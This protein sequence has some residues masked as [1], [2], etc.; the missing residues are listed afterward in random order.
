MGSFSSTIIGDSGDSLATLKLESMFDDFKVVYLART[1]IDVYLLR[2]MRLESIRKA[3][4]VSKASA[5]FSG[6]NTLISSGYNIYDV[7]GGNIR[8]SIVCYI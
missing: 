1:Y 6:E 8:R 2:Y 4:S 5:R 3:A 7:C